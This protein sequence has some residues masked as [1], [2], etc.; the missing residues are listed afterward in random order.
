MRA[1]L[2]A[3]VAAA[4][5]GS[6]YFAL[7]ASLGGHEHAQGHETAAPRHWAFRLTIA[8]PLAGEPPP[9]FKARQ[10]DTITLIVRSDRPGEL[11][12]HGIEKVVTL[13]PQGAVKLTFVAR[14]AG[15][16]PLHLHSP[17]GTMRHL[18]LLE[19]DP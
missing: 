5:L 3:A 15:G 11:H 13:N 7:K 8:E 2:W 1:I 14:D 4:V 9:V 18:A 12:V 10:G 19:V 17:D 16:F 6:L